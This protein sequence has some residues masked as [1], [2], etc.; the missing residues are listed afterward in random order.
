MGPAEDEAAVGHHAGSPV[1]ELVAADAV[2]RIIIDEFSD[3][4]V[5]FS[6]TVHGGYPDVALAVLPDV[7]Y[8]ETRSSG[9]GI[10]HPFLGIVAED[11]I[12]YGAYP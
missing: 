3:C 2:S 9:N 12:G 11:A 5:I 4:T 7:A 6:Q 8:V 1:G 10:S